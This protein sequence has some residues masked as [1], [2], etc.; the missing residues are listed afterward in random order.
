MAKFDEIYV[1]FKSGSL[2]EDTFDDTYTVNNEQFNAALAEYEDEATESLRIEESDGVIHFIDRDSIR[3]ISFI[4]AAAVEE[5]DD[6][7][8]EDFAADA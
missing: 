3:S 7:G 5:D 1:V 6:D 8:D 2:A 4:P